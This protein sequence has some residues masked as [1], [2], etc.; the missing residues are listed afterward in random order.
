MRGIR[1]ISFFLISALV[2]AACWGIAAGAVAQESA[3]PANVVPDS[4][5][6]DS[7][8][9]LIEADFAIPDLSDRVILLQARF[10]ALA[11]HLRGMEGRV[12]RDGVDERLAEL[13]LPERP[14]EFRR[15]YKS[16][17]KIAGGAGGLDD[18]QTLAGSYLEKG[19]LDDAMTA[20]FTVYRDSK[21][22]PQRA[23][24]V[25][26]MAEAA[27]AKGELRL[28]LNL[29]SKAVEIYGERDLRRRLATL[30]ERH[31]LRVED[32]AIDV[33]N[34][35]PSACVVFTQSLSKR[36]PLPI[37]DYVELTPAGDV[38]IAA[39]DKSICLRGLEFGGDYT[40]RLRPG[41]VGAEGARMY[42]GFE[43][44]FRVNDRTPRILFAANSYVLAKTGASGLP[45]KTVNLD[46]VDL[47]LYRIDDRNLVRPI[48]AGQLDSNLYGSEEGDL[49]ASTGVLVWQGR[50]AV[51]AQ[52]NQEITTL[53]PVGE[54]LPDRKPGLY[55]VVARL[56]DE[57]PEDSWR[58]HAT[59]WLVLSDLGLV[60]FQGEDGLHLLARSLETALPLAGVEFTLVARNNVLLGSAISGADGLARFAPGLL[61]GAGG[62]RPAFVTA[63]TAAGDHNFLRLTGAALDLSERGIEGREAPKGLDAFLYSERGVYRPGEKVYLSALLRDARAAAKGGLPLTVKVTRPGG[64]EAYHRT[65]KGDDLGG[66]L[67]E[68][69]LSPAARPGSWVAQAYLDPTKAPVGSTVFQVEDFVPP[70]LE[71]ELEA[72]ADWLVPG[73]GTDV[74]LTGR[75]LYGPPA[76]D[77]ETE[78]RLALLV[79]PTP[80]PGYETFR[81]GL[82]QEDY[83]PRRQSLASARTDQEGRAV[84]RLTVDQVPDSSH[85]LMA[86]LRA[87]LLDLGGRPVQARLRL[88][89][90]TRA[91]ELGLRPLFGGSPK[92]E[93]AR[94]GA[95]GEAVYDLVALDRSGQPVP[96][97]A[98]AYE[99]LREIYDYSWYQQGGEWR[100][101]TT[102][103][104]EVVATG[105]TVLGDDGRGQLSR[106]LGDGRYR[107]EVFDPSA[108]VNGGSIASHRFSAGWWYGPAAPD[109]PDALELSLE[110]DSLRDGE[111]LKAFLRAPFAGQAVVTVMND[112][113]RH[114]ETLALPAEGRKIALPVDAA[115]G[116]GAYLMVT[117]FRPDAGKP[118][119]LPVRAMGLAWFSI[120][121]AETTLEVEITV[122]DSVLPRQEVSLPIT[123][124]GAASGE[125][126]RV[127]LAAVDDGI[128]QLTGYRPPSPEDHYLGKRRLAMDVRDLY[129]RLIRPLEG[130]PGRLRSGG[131]RA[132][133]NLQGISLRSVK[134]VALYQR[135]IEL[136]DQGRATVTL[137]LPDFNGRLRLMAVA[138]G[139]SR[140]GSGSA[141]LIVRD[142]MIA[143]LLLPR[144]L[145]LDDLAE[146]TLDLQNLSGA[147]Q[148]VTVQVA[149]EGAVALA[150]AGETLGRFEV[151]L[152]PDARE[153]LDL[154]VEG[155]AVG[156]GALSLSVEGEGLETIERHWDLEVR[157]AQPFI[158]ERQVRI[159][160]PGER[161]A[162]DGGSFAGFLPET[163]ETRITVTAGADFNLPDLLDSLDRYPYGCT[164][165][166]VSRAFPLL[167]YGDL[168]EQAARDR[169]DQDSARRVDRSIRRILERQRGDGSFATW[170]SY[171]R[172]EPWLSAYVFDFLTRAKDA[173]HAVPPA[174]YDHTL[175]WLEAYAQQ[176]SG[177]L[178]AR[179]YAFYALARIGKAKASSLRYFAETYGDRIQTRLG[180]G[181]V[182]AALA[183]LGER[184]RAELFF[185]KAIANRRPRAAVIRDY[186]SD[187]RDGAAIAALLAE[188]FPGT[189]RALRLADALEGDFDL[190]QYFSTQ[191][192]AWLI[193]ATHALNSGE[194]AA[195]RVALNDGETLSRREALRRRLDHAALDA[196]FAVENRG[197]AP[198][199]VIGATRGVPRD[200]LPA[201]AT[202]FSLTRT[203]YSEAGA[204]TDLE[205]VKQNDRFVVLI[206]GRAENDREQQALV[207]DLLPAGFEIENSALGGD[208]AD[209]SFAFLPPLSET[210]FTAARD[211]RYVAALDLAGR[212]HFAVAYLVRAV[213]P[214]RFA[215]PG[216]FV[217]DMYRPKFHARTARAD[218]TIVRP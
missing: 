109:V 159:L 191:E 187:L 161:L 30:I 172:S 29:Y 8:R 171:G 36:L 176:S 190:R 118:S 90:R 32:V 57:K 92:A 216:S 111:V 2:G 166:T 212:Q 193:L 17:L 149:A 206:E 37:E 67:F 39:R 69:P 68:V 183:F 167:Y 42:G 123:V 83:R 210:A 78:A 218:I 4:V 114:S 146:A 96:G 141:A 108:E 184:E 115:W 169:D 215:L 60:T 19:R 168:A 178:Y 124:A 196:G 179:A 156:T 59:Q 125:A 63:S 130:Q 209:R 175:A 73:G 104:D 28:A 101:R 18:W 64:A 80:F 120:D 173:G 86:E 70:R 35:L 110:R 38:D 87:G 188:A 185:E 7:E 133:E 55:V 129:G 47:K 127:T 211:D 131:D 46:A 97:Q 153:T 50:L 52:R 198:L 202:G 88:P 158:T 135:D 13:F 128:L 139:R 137:D 71:A 213:T 200:P 54:I 9:P 180:L 85:P 106:R 157:A 181:Q 10:L 165:Q 66:Y 44:R 140:V 76:A 152:A 192:E 25:A 75:F 162:L 72:E 155:V 186:G 5:V 136:D 147:S 82:V 41:L 51:E 27:L 194:G 102:V 126:L 164:E 89:I 79:D 34:R 174:A 21:V 16:E 112:G 26:A 197:E 43:R 154:R 99:W 84:I 121:R 142:P 12:S 160:A 6:R 107:L 93:V 49:E 182:A 11:E 170:E 144:F 103:Y 217:E 151:T 116:P 119:P 113:L 53:V 94:L 148:S 65:L 62:E 20:A 33:E 48:L 24:A 74:V 15:D 150:G 61:R 23:K 77:L 214:G 199:R 138:Y 205:A 100:F 98:V 203:F 58:Q 1:Q 177:A 105:E 31:D 204:V 207:V 3:V 201:A 81:F 189:E 145:A 163:L 22:E 56:P 40:L 143:D 132:G 91:V 134:T 95:D 45:V 122:P 14:D 117:A 195:Y 208:G